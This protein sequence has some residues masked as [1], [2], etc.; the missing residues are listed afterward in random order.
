MIGL[1]PITCWLQISCSANW[2][3]SACCNRIKPQKSHFHYLNDSKGIWTPVTA[4]KG[5]C[6]NRLTMEP[7]RKLNLISD[8]MFP[9]TPP[10]GL[11]PTTLRLTAA[12]STDWAMEDHSLSLFS[13]H[14][15]SKLHTHNILLPTALRSTVPGQTLDRLVTVSSMHCC[16]STSALST[17]SSS[18]GLT[19]F[20]WDISSWGGLHA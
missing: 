3:T 12:C 5:R 13:L 11:E 8:F 4:V 17:S 7:G 14:V 18:R 6:L 16:T 15:P 9:K 2:A 20:E 1:E 10:V 19:S